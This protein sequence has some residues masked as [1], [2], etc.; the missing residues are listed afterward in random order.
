MSRYVDEWFRP[1]GPG[2]AETYKHAAP[3][4]ERTPRFIDP[5]FRKGGPDFGVS[6]VEPA[7][8]PAWARRLLARDP[9]DAGFLERLTAAWRDGRILF[10]RAA[11][12]APDRAGRRILA[13]TIRRGT[14]PV[15][16]DHGG[17]PVGTARLIP[18]ATDVLCAVVLNDD[19]RGRLTARVVA[20]GG[21]GLSV[22][23]S[24]PAGRP[25]GW[26]EG[27]LFQVDHV[28]LVATP[29][30]PSCRVLNLDHPDAVAFLTKT[31]DISEK[32]LGL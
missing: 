9:A 4:V 12:E 14:V 11:S 6:V 13:G 24:Q 19:A 32:E 25:G 7:P 10:G 3:V 30:D 22:N 31:L 27:D 20:G 15:L 18:G 21:S 28:S 1:G 29:Q 23:G 16:I 26:R 5:W 17:A 8:L 2:S